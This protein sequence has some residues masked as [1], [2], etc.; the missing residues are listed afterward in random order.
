MEDST[1]HVTSEEKNNWN[2]KAAGIIITIPPTLPSATAM[3]APFMSPPRIKATGTAKRRAVILTA[4]RISPAELCPS[5]GAEP[6]KLNYGQALP[7]KKQFEIWFFLGKYSILSLFG[8]G[9]FQYGNQCD[10]RCSFRQR[11]GGG[12]YLLHTNR[13]SE[14]S[15]LRACLKATPILTLTES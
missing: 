9:I 6:V 15:L 14:H 8:Y 4:R 12:R 5:P 2:S 10:F 7:L 3:I 1:I 13:Q 11:Y